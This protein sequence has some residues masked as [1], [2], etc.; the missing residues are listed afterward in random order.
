M[1][2]GVCSRAAGGHRR[3]TR[4]RVCAAALRLLEGRERKQERLQ[5]I[6]D[7]GDGRREADP[8]DH[9]SKDDDHDDAPLRLHEKG[10]CE[11]DGLPNGG[12]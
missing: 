5:G 2:T 11:Q 12:Q 7:S 4:K 8:H 9:D 6:L 3:V 1:P 10:Q